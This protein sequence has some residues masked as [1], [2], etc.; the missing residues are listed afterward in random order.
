MRGNGLQPSRSQSF[1]VVVRMCSLLLDEVLGL[2]DRGVALVQ[3]LVVE[4]LEAR[5]SLKMVG[6]IVEESVELG[7]VRGILGLAVGLRAMVGMT[8]NI[9][10]VLLSVLHVLAII[11]LVVLTLAI[12]DLPSISG[13]DVGVL[14][15]V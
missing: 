13:A 2:F 9:S 8:M 3:K 6:L 1:E 15:E 5:V 7:E 11:D 14:A 4:V 10:K 12:S